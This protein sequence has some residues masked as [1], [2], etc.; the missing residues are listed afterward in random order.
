M[1]QYS[2]YLDKKLF[3]FALSN[4]C[5]VFLKTALLVSAFDKIIYRDEELI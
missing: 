3:I 4:S 1:G 2:Y 5:D